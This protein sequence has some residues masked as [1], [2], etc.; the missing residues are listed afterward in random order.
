MS[1][2]RCNVC[3]QLD[4]ARSSR[5][6]QRLPERLALVVPAEDNR[7]RRPL[8]GAVK[9][10]LD[11]RAVRIEDVS[12]VVTRVIRPFAGRAVITASGG[13]GRFVESIHGLTVGCLEREVQPP[14]DGA[15]VADEEFVGREPALAF[16][17]EAQTE[18]R[19]RPGV[20][21][22]ACL[23]VAYAQM[24]VVEKPAGMRFGHELESMGPTRANE[25]P[26]PDA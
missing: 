16:S 12:A 20:E 6:S 8:H 3:A 2:A 14:G 24:D 1:R 23:D 7:G 10:R 17:R 19:E 13:D 4:D 25:E 9:H 11:V 26:R 22:L 15:V 18:R 5:R 21:P